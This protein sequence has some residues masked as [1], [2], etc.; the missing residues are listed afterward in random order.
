MLPLMCSILCPPT[1]ISLAES[2]PLRSGMDP[3]SSR[4]GPL[5]PRMGPHRPGI[6]PLDESGLRRHDLEPL[7]R[8]KEP[9]RT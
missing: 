4:I 6:S 8:E 3:L 2:L 7:R 9:S 1:Q 5:M